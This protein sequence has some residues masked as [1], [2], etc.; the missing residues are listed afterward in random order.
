MSEEVKK[1]LESGWKIEVNYGG[2]VDGNVGKGE[3]EEVSLPGVTSNK[4]LC[5]MCYV[6]CATVY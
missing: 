6:L 1:K 4:V 2:Y 5:A 3:M